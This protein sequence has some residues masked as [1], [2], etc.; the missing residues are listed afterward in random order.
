M[1]LKKKK[2]PKRD[3]ELARN[4]GVCEGEGWNN[5][6]TP[7]H[8]WVLNSTCCNFNTS[9]PVIDSVVSANPGRFSGRFLQTQAVGV[10]VFFW[11]LRWLLRGCLPPVWLFTVKVCSGSPCCHAWKQ[12][13][14]DTGGSS[15]RY[16]GSPE[17]ILT[18]KLLPCNFRSELDSIRFFFISD[19][20]FSTLVFQAGVPHRKCSKSW[21]T[22]K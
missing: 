20:C 15:Q 18:L 3:A 21:P 17:V 19:L 5:E 7:L 6:G 9:A 16:S 13:F 10:T 12:S 1:L 14:P 22:G 4:E 8:L 2:L 11:T